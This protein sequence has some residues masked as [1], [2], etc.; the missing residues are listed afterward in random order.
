MKRK[1][2]NRNAFTMIELIFVI[3]IA[4]I[5]GAFTLDAIRQY[6]ESIFKNKEYSQRVSDADHI[7]DQLSKYFENAISVSIVNLDI[8]PGTVHCFG[9]PQGNAGDFTVAFIG[10]DTDSQR[11]TSGG[12]GWNEDMALLSGT[13]L[14]SP[15]S[16]FTDV[17]NMIN[18]VYGT[19][20]TDAAL[21]NANSANVGA[22]QR[23]RMEGGAGG[24]GYH[25]INGY[26]ASSLTLNNADLSAMDGKRK[27]MLRTGYA[28]RV[29][30][31]GDF[32]MHTNYRPWAGQYYTAGQQYLLGEN[33]AHFYADYDTSDF[34]DQNV[35][36]RGLVWRLKVCMRGISNDLNDSNDQGL[37]ICR[38]R[39]VHVRY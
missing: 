5:V 28:F 35:T 13:S 31:N 8:N 24:E 18:S 32:W 19:N 27:Y 16:N 14:S 38:E 10:V 2:S 30:A 22:C 9:P 4:G 21:F 17:H 34:D 33:V 36:D 39:R 37:G 26:T 15:D 12:P 29:D 3:V 6:Y 25:R 7:L 23:F 1:P 20:I 11:G